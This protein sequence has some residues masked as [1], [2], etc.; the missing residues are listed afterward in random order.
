MSTGKDAYVDD[1]TIAV[2]DN[3]SRVAATLTKAVDNAVAV[4]EGDLKMTVNRVKS[5]VVASKPSVAVAT[6]AASRTRTL[7]PAR[8]SKLLGTPAA[9]GARRNA[10]VT[11]ERIGKVN[12]LIPRLQALR[13]K[14]VKT[15]TMARA[16]GTAAMTYGVEIRGMAPTTLATARTTIAK[17]CTGAA[18]GKNPL[19]VL[20]TH[21]AKDG[22]LDP[23]F[24]AF[25]LPVKHWALAWWE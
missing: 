7:K 20:Y 3:T 15:A 1:L 11:K 2:R 19:A 12:K 23:A 21:D 9:G 22:T 24:D 14:G 6:A 17:A 10:M 4:L 16:A 18:G 5:K 25:G 13:T 8:W